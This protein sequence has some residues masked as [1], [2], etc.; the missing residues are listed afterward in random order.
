M[1]S[2]IQGLDRVQRDTQSVSDRLLQTTRAAASSEE[3]LLGAAEQIVRTL[4]NLPA[5]ETGAAGCDRA[6]SDALKGLVFFTNIARI[7]RNG[8]VICASRH[9]GVGRDVA[10]RAVFQRARTSN[11][12]VVSEQIESPINDHPVIAGMLPMHNATGF[13]GTIAIAI[14]V[15]WLDYMVRAKQLPK[16]AVVAIFDRKGT[17]IAANQPDIARPVFAHANAVR[18]AG[19]NL[20]TATDATGRNWLYST[21]ALLGSSVYVGFGMPESRLFGATYVNVGTDFLLP[22]LMVALSWIAIWIVTERQ[23]T[24]WIVYLRRVSAAYRSGHYSLRPN[25]E[26]APSEFRMLGRGMAEMAAAIQDRDR[27]LHDALDQKSTLIGEIHH[28]VKNNLQIVMSLLSLQAGRVHD[29]AAQEAL[30][31]AQARINAL[32]LVHRILH[33][34]EDLT[35]VDL[36]RLLIDLAQQTREGFAADRSDLKLA[37]DLVPRQVSGDLAVPLA[38]FTVEAL[39]NVFKHAFPPPRQAGTIT[40]RLAPAGGGKLRLA[41]QDDGEGYD[42]KENGSHVGAKLI[43]TFGQQVGGTTAIRSET[44][45][46]TVSELIFPDPACHGADGVNPE[47]APPDVPAAP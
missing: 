20:Y 18:T 14:D 21:T 39:T 29:P 38:L 3:N 47:T 40:V 22:F 41:V 8:K 37:F 23:V 33:D 35:A 32:A 5:V 34:I 43:E 42:A 36:S 45:K 30:R 31:Q 46:G 2:F 26:G 13:D 28:R 17:V 7:D 9:E 12:F 10:G 27:R 16:G 1:A 11:D 15:R 6:L 25:L 19:K 24:R 4:A 44:G